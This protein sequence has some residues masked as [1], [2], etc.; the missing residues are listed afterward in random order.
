MKP[1]DQMNS[2]L[3]APDGKRIATQAGSA[4]YLWDGDRASLSAELSRHDGPIDLT[5]FSADGT[6]LA[7]GSRDKTVRLWDSSTGKALGETL[8]HEHAVEFD[9]L[10][11]GWIAHRNGG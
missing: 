4:A 11:G 5:V 8:R 10:Y 1:P 6:R 3:F 2:A 9:R 7:T